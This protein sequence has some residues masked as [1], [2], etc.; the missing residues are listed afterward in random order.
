MGIHAPLSASS[1]IS[2]SVDLIDL[3]RNTPFTRHLRTENE[4]VRVG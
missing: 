4:L 3:D 2:R 1:I